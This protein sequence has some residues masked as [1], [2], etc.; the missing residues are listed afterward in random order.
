MDFNSITEKIKIYLL[1]IH[2]E[3]R[4]EIFSSDVKENEAITGSHMLYQMEDNFLPKALF[5]ILYL[6][7]L[8]HS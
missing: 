3:E 1:H 8:L 7:V 2:I 5:W 6:L 4:S